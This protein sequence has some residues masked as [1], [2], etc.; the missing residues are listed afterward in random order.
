[1]V[2]QYTKGTGRGTLIAADKSF[3]VFERLQLEMH[4]HV[5]GSSWIES[6]AIVHFF[7]QFIFLMM[8]GN[9]VLIIILYL[10][11]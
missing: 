8:L 6:G 11:L 10:R 4:M 5:A 3:A 7:E 9:L 1:M 2:L